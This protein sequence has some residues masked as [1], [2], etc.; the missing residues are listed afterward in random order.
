M[1]AA[2]L[3]EKLQALSD[4]QKQLQ[5]YAYNELEEAYSEAEL[6]KC[7]PYENAR[8]VGGDYPW[9]DNP[10]DRPERNFIEISD[11]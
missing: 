10:N 7:K 11:Y 9:R 2:Q 3:I 6:V 5:V 1:T 8:Y 4:E